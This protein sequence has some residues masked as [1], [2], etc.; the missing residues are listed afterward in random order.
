MNYRSLICSL[1]AMTLS[2]GLAQ[3]VR[4]AVEPDTLADLDREVQSLRVD[5]V[6]WRTIEWK[7]CL[8]D[9]LQA[10][11]TQK[12]PL[13]LWIFIDRPIDDERC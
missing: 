10:A 13:M 11:H 6:A 1:A 12:K 4:P 5:K 9:G 2:S 7:T 8:L 3:D